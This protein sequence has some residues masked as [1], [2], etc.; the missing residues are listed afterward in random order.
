MNLFDS[1]VTLRRRAY[2]ILLAAS[3]GVM[4]GGAVA[5][6]S[7]GVYGVEALI[8]P[9]QISIGSHQKFPG[10]GGL[11]SEIASEHNDPR[12]PLST[13]KRTGQAIK[14]LSAL[15][16]TGPLATELQFRFGK[17]APPFRRDTWLEGV[18]IESGSGSLIRLLVISSASRAKAEILASDILTYL[19]A[20]YRP[21][22][23]QFR[24]LTERRIREIEAQIRTKERDLD[25]VS[26]NLESLGHSPTLRAE[27]ERTLGLLIQ[28]R[29]THEELSLS[30]APSNSYNY[31]MVA[32]QPTDVNPPLQSGLT[33][34]L[35]GLAFAI[36]MG[37]LVLGL[38]LYKLFRPRLIHELNRV[39]EAIAHPLAR[40]VNPAS[41]PESA[42]KVTPVI[43]LREQ[44]PESAAPPEGDD[45]TDIHHKAS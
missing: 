42:E 43:P 8:R 26:R 45:H 18:S 25:L 15:A 6:R 30:I 17:E 21:T 7:T 3:I 39:N 36:V 14:L 41:K 2:L 20:Q 32:I 29:G 10:S 12:G 9:G 33:S 16:D 40:D 27:R 31:E 22:Y 24:S 44:P 1:L 11:L 34:A 4:V 38:E 13:K 28:Y 23:S 37:A 19:Q 35:T 5:T